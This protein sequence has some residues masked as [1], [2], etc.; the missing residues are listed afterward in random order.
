MYLNLSNCSLQ[1]AGLETVVMAIQKLIYLQHLDLSL[2]SFT[3]KAAHKVS[4]LIKGTSRN[5]CVHLSNSPMEYNTLKSNVTL[6]FDNKRKI[7]FVVLKILSYKLEFVR[8][9]SQEWKSEWIINSSK[10]KYLCISFSQK[11]VSKEDFNL[12]KGFLAD[13]PTIEHLEIAIADLNQ[14]EAK[15]LFQALSSSRSLVYLNISY[16]NISNEAADDLAVVIINNRLDRLSMHDCRMNESVMLKIVSAL[17]KN[18]RLKCLDL[19]ANLVSNPAA[20]IIASIITN[21]NTIEHLNIS[22]C[23]LHNDSFLVLITLLQSIHA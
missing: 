20:T 7:Q 19:S 1:S 5:F 9:Q 4:Q 17:Q 23:K 21:N 12:L 14:T 22:S 3:E 18:A 13:S 11:Q 16:S 10:I 8:M 2:N 6:K 15:D